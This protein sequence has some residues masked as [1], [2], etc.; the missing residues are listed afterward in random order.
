[1]KFEVANQHTTESTNDSSTEP[2][3]DSLTSHSAPL[4]QPWSDPMSDD[5]TTDL[6]FGYTIGV[7]P[8]IN[9]ASDNQIAT[10]TETD[11]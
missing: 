5:A 8:N 9:S 2:A 3:Y 10:L 6:S 4:L 1:M 11:S 7:F